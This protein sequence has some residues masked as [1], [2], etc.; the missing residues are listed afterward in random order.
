VVGR[1]LFGASV[2]EAIPVVMAT[3]PV[4]SEHALRRGVNPFRL[5]R[6]WPTPAGR[7]AVRAQ[8]ALYKT[9][10]KIIAQ[11]EVEAAHMAAPLGPSAGTGSTRGGAEAERGGAATGRD[12]VSQLL[13]ARDPETGGP[14]SP[15]EVRDQALIFLIAGQET[16]ATTV[17]LAIRLLGSHPKVQRAVQDELD[18]VLHGRTPTVAD[19]PKL[20]YTAMVVKEALRLYPPAPSL[21]RLATVDDRIGPYKIRAGSVVILSPWVTHRRPDIWPDPHRFD[22]ERFAPERG[23]Y[24]KYA[25]LPFGAGPRACVGAQFATIETIVAIATLLSTFDVQTPST[26]LPMR[27]GITLRPAEPVTCAVTPRGTRQDADRARG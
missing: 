11:R 19:L 9:V 6:S 8:R 7:R 21:G 12:L 3:F 17:T 4:L 20:T 18:T 14:L 15:R 16:T 10:D 22:P 24:H 2:D 5:P 25:Y 26:A 27:T 23:A 13:G 1:A